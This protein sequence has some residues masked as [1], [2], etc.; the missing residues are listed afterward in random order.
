MRASEFITERKK[1]KISKIHHQATKGLHTFTD[2][3]Y[4]LNRV[5]MAVAAS[6]GQSPPK[7]DAESWIG[8][9]VNTAHPYSEIEHDMLKAAY[10]ALGLKFTDLNKNDMCSREM[11]STN[12]KSTLKPFKGY[13]K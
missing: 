5:M 7:I 10:K 8:N 9:K 13:K 6:D 12:T 1:G 3:T 4:D 11:D 2:S